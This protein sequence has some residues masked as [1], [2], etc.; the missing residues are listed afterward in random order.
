MREHMFAKHTFAVREACPRMLGARRCVVV[1]RLCALEAA[2]N[3][4]I[5][6]DGKS[7]LGSG[8]FLLMVRHRNFTL[9][10]QALSPLA[11]FLELQRSPKS[12]HIWQPFRNLRPGP[13]AG[14]SARQRSI[15]D[16]RSRQNAS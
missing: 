7:A 10:D 14:S 15:K 1:G 9:I 4:S 3:A 11:T 2:R 8:G 12:S 16:K 6:E 13:S 5:A